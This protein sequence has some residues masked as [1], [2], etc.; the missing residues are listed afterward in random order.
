M[1]TVQCFPKSIDLYILPFEVPNQIVSPTTACPLIQP[2]SLASGAGRF[3][4][5]TLFHFLPLLLVMYTSKYPPLGSPM[6]IPWFLS[7]KCTNRGTE[8]LSKSSPGLDCSH[9]IPASVV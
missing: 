6:A 8:L 3:C 1:W 9:V 2:T 7:L 5:G 4:W